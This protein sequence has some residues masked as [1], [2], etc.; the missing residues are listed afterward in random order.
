MK[1]IIKYKIL[2]LAFIIALSSC[3]D[4]I[5]DLMPSATGKLGELVVVIKKDYWQSELGEE[6]KNAFASNK[7][8][9]TRDEPEF[10]LIQTYGPSWP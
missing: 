9:L 4:D 5:R 8:M 2:F 3:K 7:K 1:K 6:L 10:D